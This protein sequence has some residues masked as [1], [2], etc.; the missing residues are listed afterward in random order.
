M[1]GCPFGVSAYVHLSP[2]SA[3]PSP[4]PPPVSK[5]TCFGD[6]FFS[7]ISAADDVVTELPIMAMSRR[8]QEEVLIKIFIRKACIIAKVE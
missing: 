1:K 5:R 7:G 6:I 2:G 8:A 4:P 3:E